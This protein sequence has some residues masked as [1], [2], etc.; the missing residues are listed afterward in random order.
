MRFDSDLQPDEGELE[1]AVKRYMRGPLF[2]SDEDEYDEEEEYWSEI[3]DAY[4]DASSDPEEDLLELESANDVIAPQTK[5]IAYYLDANLKERLKAAAKRTQ[6]TK[7]V[8]AIR[9]LEGY[10]KSKPSK[11]DLK[12][13][14]GSKGKIFLFDEVPARLWSRVDDFCKNKKGIR[15]IKI[16]HVVEQAIL[17]AVIEIENAK[18]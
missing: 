12:Q 3:L 14:K 6:V 2:G 7:R 18:G 4:T 8:F 10:L 5:K 16:T 1:E 17:E 13:L 9:A 11:R 15:K